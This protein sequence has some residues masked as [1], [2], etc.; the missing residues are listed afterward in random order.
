MGQSGSFSHTF[1]LAKDLDRFLLLFLCVVLEGMGQ[2]HILSFNLD[3]LL[4]WAGRLWLTAGLD[5]WDLLPYLES[6]GEPN[7]WQTARQ[8]S[9]CVSSIAE[10]VSVFFF[11]LT[12][13]SCNLIKCQSCLDCLLY[14]PSS[15]VTIGFFWHVF[16]CSTY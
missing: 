9:R 1:T 12:L 4:H 6:A 14:N 16:I 3:D 10:V 13:Y 15:H 2:Q 8:R 11:L 7:D 5:L